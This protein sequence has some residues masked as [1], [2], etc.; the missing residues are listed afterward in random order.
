M[1]SQ[2]TPLSSSSP[3]L[4]L[5]QVASE[6]SYRLH[7]YV[8][9]GISHAAIPSLIAILKTSYPLTV[10]TH[11]FLSAEQHAALVTRCWDDGRCQLDGYRLLDTLEQQWSIGGTEAE[12]QR[13]DVREVEESQMA[14]TARV[15]ATTASP[16]NGRKRR[17]R[18]EERSCDTS[19]ET[20]G[21]GVEEEGEVEEAKRQST[22]SLSR[23]FRPPP[24]SSGRVSGERLVSADSAVSDDDLPLS[25]PP[26][27]IFRPA[28][29]YQRP[30]RRSW[31]GNPNREQRFPAVYRYSS[32]NE[33][34]Q[35]PNVVVEHQ[36]IDLSLFL[37][38][39]DCFVPQLTWVFGVARLFK[40]ALVSTHRLTLHSPAASAA[41]LYKECVHE[42]GHLF[43]LHHCSLPCVM[44]Y[45]TS[46]EE[47]LQKDSALCGT[48]KWKVGWMESGVHIQVIAHSLTHTAQEEQ[49]RG[50]IYHHSSVRTVRT[51]RKTTTMAVSTTR[52]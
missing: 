37:T 23:T 17:R 50:M 44:T 28:S 13:R 34:R 6:W 52:M 18:E 14:E 35:Y 51:C 43:G 42:V 46:V 10:I 9:L 22:A 4:S 41:F 30:A 21:R 45:S 5:Q 47:A 36:H 2:S 3:P 29:A 1:S 31:D 26:L 48:C 7:C 49:Q 38:P 20:D 40:C 33:L 32:L 16:P 25:A 12:R 24:S 19:D 27:P 11:S 39:L 8:D 15:R